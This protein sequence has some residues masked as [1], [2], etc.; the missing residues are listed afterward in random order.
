MFSW[1]GVHPEIGSRFGSMM[2]CW[3]R[4]KAAWAD[5][6][7]YS[8]KECLTSV[9]EP[10]GVLLVN[11]GGGKGHHIEGYPELKGRLIRRDLPS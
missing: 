10:Y 1:F 11:V 2:V 4:D 6:N 7:A 8:V 3:M 9:E 5:E